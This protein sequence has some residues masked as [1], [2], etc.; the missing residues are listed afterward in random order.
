L[1]CELINHRDTENTE[2]A[3]RRAI[4]EFCAKL[5]FAVQ[6]MGD[7][8]AV[9]TGV[10]MNKLLVCSVLPLRRQKERSRTAD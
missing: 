9:G 8:T 2:V 4:D 5:S 1:C 6:F 3:Q 10:P 7:S